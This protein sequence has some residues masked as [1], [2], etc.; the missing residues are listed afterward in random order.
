VGEVRE[1]AEDAHE[2]DV[3]IEILAQ[4][5]QTPAIFHGAE[6][7]VYP[8]WRNPHYS[9]RSRADEAAVISDGFCHRVCSTWVGLLIRDTTGCGANMSTVSLSGR[10]PLLLE[11]A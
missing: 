6:R 4:P 5:A 2:R 9:C 1:D 7:A 3:E 10:K 11:D 8:A